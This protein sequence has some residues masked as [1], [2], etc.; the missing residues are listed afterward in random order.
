MV[1]LL[2]FEPAPATLPLVQAV[3]PD[4]SGER[5]GCPQAYLTDNAI[6][7]PAGADEPSG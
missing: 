3:S 5:L 1:A 7:R 6:A 2:L 4:S